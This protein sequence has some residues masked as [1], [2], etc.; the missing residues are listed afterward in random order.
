M[1]KY[2]SLVSI[3]VFTLLFSGYACS[4]NGPTTASVALSWTQSTSAGVTANCVYRGSVAGTYAKP[5]LFCSTAPI[6]SYVDTSV[7][8]GSTWHYSVTAQA[9]ALEGSY[10]NDVTAAVP[11]APAAPTVNNPTYTKLEKS[12]KPVLTAKVVWR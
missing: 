12:E 1:R 2:L 11:L 9:G 4:Q 3:L 8:R 10:S 7:A 5:A 6:T